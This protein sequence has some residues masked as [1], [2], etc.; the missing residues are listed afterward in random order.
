MRRRM[1]SLRPNAPIESVLLQFKWS[2]YEGTWI[3][4]FVWGF[5]STLSAVL[6]VICLIALNHES[7]MWCIDATTD[8]LCENFTDNA[9]QQKT[10]KTVD[11]IDYELVVFN[12]THN[13]Q[14]HL[15]IRRT[16]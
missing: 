5:S 10:V 13:V 9:V 14:N 7:I 3:Y 16:K 11:C 15:P 4:E 2:L 8:S 1:S 6:I 12:D